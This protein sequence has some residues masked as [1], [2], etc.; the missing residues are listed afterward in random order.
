VER[1]TA[2]MW[3]SEDYLGHTGL[4]CDVSGGIEHV[5]SSS[6]ASAYT[7]SSSL[8]CLLIKLLF[9]SLYPSA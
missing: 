7:L 5:S 6:V 1:A 3:R 8:T 2:H 9:K 4:S